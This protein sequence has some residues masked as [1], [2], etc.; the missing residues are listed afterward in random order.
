MPIDF[1]RIIIACLSG[2]IYSL[3]GCRSQED[4][5]ARR[6]P[7]TVGRR[8]RPRRGGMSQ[9]AE[10]DEV[11]C[12]AS[13]LSRQF[14]S[15]RLAQLNCPLPC[16]SPSALATASF[17]PLFSFGCRRCQQRLR[18]LRCLCL[19][20]QNNIHPLLPPI[21]RPVAKGF[22]PTVNIGTARLL[23]PK[24]V[25]I[26]MTRLPM[27][28]RGVL[29]QDRIRVSSVMHQAIQRPLTPIITLFSLHLS[30]ECASA[31]HAPPKPLGPR[32]PY[33]DAA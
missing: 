27:R 30:S 9:R 21:V 16:P 22:P 29:T 1:Y 6:V 32:N 7:W 14:S 11:G 20:Q 28:T 18:S 2:C 15:L 3:R 10:V 23:R 24:T 12:A 26:T 25:Q 17:R 33:P 5:S 13:C 4:Q 8:A 31:I 19:I